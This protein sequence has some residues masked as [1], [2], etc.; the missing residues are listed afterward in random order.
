MAG[1]SD[2]L[3]QQLDGALQRYVVEPSAGMEQRLMASMRAAATHEHRRTWRAGMIWASG[4]A[5]TAGMVL[6]VTGAPHSAR[7]AVRSSA[8][9][10]AA[11]APTPVSRG[12]R[13][14]I[15]AKDPQLLAVRVPQRAGR[16]ESL[17]KLAVFPAPVPLSPQ[18]RAL[19]RLAAEPKLAAEVLQPAPA[20]K[21]A[22]IE[23]KP[24]EIAPLQVAQLGPNRNE[25]LQPP[26]N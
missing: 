26:E 1:S 25:A 8:T 21:I 22:P 9:R 19:E 13:I 2:D 4:L 18:E 14:A 15:P 11:V 20:L 6:L 3:D 5:L 23:I 16:P 7:T 12:P 17:P 24:L 10:I